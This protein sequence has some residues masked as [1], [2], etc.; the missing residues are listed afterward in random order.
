M[1]KNYTRIL[2]ESFAEPQ[3]SEDP[4]ERWEGFKS[5]ILDSANECSEPTKR[6]NKC[7]IY[8]ETLDIIEARR[9]ARLDGKRE[10]ISGR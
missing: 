3:L 8:A 9:Q 6:A 7:F 1:S 10:L 5:A 4:V 2:G